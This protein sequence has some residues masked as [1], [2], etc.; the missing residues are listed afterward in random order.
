[1][2]LSHF[3]GSFEGSSFGGG[4]SRGDGKSKVEPPPSQQ[5]D[6]R[7]VLQATKRAAEREV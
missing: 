4:S 3:W 1:M 2:D 6:R 5:K 7:L